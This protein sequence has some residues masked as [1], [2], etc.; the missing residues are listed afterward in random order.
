LLVVVIEGDSKTA[1][2]K[3]PPDD[4]GGFKPWDP[5]EEEPKKEEEKKPQPRPD[6]VV[7]RIK[8]TLTA[9][10]NYNADLNVEVP[11]G[12]KIVLGMK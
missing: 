8:V 2:A 10:T 11:D 9:K 12:A 7:K 5:D 1:P 3:P 4:N 6:A